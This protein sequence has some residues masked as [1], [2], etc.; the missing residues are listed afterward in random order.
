MRLS[1]SVTVRIEC[2]R[3]GDKALRNVIVHIVHAC[4][5]TGRKFAQLVRFS[6][7]SL[8]VIHFTFESVKSVTAL[9]IQ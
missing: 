3:R 7:R 1:Y 2:Q 8:T 9:H 6:G 5:S 4:Y